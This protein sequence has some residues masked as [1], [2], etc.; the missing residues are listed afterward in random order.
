MLPRPVIDPS[1][2]AEASNPFSGIFKL[3]NNTIYP[4]EDVRIEADLWCAKIGRGADTSP[5][6]ACPRIGMPSSRKAWNKRTI[7]RDDAYQIN[8]GEILYAT[9]GALLSAD[10]SLKVSYR[11]WGLPFHLDKEYRFYT[12]RKDDGTIEWLHRPNDDA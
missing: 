6:D 3:T 2:P 10:V 12:R 8:I 5:P 11:P 7:A 1:S 4:L 9:P